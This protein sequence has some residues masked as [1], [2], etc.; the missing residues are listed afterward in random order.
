MKL[1]KKGTC[2]ASSGLKP[3]QFSAGCDWWDSSCLW[4]V[5][6]SLVIFPTQGMV[7]QE[8]LLHILDD[9]QAFSSHRV[10]AAIRQCSSTASQCKVN[11]LAES[12]T[13]VLGTLSPHLCAFLTRIPSA[14]LSL[15]LSQAWELPKKPCSQW[16]DRNLHQE[17]QW[18]G[19]RTAKCI[20]ND[21]QREE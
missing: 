12:Q 1:Q 8:G 19:Q 21:Y 6:M 11:L 16:F 14:V 2:D 4:S 10:T 18:E 20:Q 17:M 13:S 7:T 5:L 3:S 9:G 15:N